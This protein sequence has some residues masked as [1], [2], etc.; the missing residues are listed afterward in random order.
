MDISVTANGGR[1]CINA[2]AIVVP[3]FGREIAD[4]L[5][6]KIGPIAPTTPEDENARLSGFANPKMAE[7]IDSSIESDLGEPGAEDMTARYR[8]GARKVE[9]ERGLFLRPTVVYCESANHPLYNREFL[10]PY[11]SVIEAPQEE[12]LEKMGP[13]L[14]LTAI[15]KDESFRAQLLEATTVDRLNFGAVP[16][17]KISWDQPHEGNMFEFLYHRRALEIGD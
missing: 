14:V 4:A 1:S 11:V 9:D 5:A 6:K 15:T 2:S 10:F 7:W 16:T 13:T 8:D 12:M 3:R 17:N